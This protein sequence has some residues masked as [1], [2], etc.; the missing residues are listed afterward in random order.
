M[1]PS[2]AALEAWAGPG[3]RFVNSSVVHWLASLHLV[4]AWYTTSAAIRTWDEDEETEELALAEL[5][6]LLQRVAALDP[7]ALGPEGNHGTHLWPAFPGPLTVLKPL[8][9]A[10]RI[11]IRHRRC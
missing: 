10:T 6:E 2:F 5:D 7:P 4:G 9:L 1:L 11:R 3:R 8:T